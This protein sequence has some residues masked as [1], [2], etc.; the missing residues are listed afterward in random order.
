MGGISET[1]SLNLTYPGEFIDG[2]YQI[3]GNIDQRHGGIQIVM[4]GGRNWH[5]K[6]YTDNWRFIYVDTETVGCDPSE[7]S[8]VGKAKLYC[9][10]ISYFPSSITWGMRGQPLCSR[11]FFFGPPNG[12]SREM[13][14]DESIG[15]GN[16]QCHYDAHVFRNEGVKYYPR[17]DSL[18]LSRQI[19]PHEKMH[20]LEK[21]M[22]EMLGYSFNIDGKGGKFKRLFSKPKVGKNGKLLKTREAIP[23]D[24]ILPFT[25]LFNR[26]VDY[27]T[28]DTKGGLEVTYL[29]LKK[30]L[31]L[32]RYRLPDYLYETYREPGWARLLRQLAGTS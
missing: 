23:L 6:D 22:A 13:L 14:E 25:P 12:L 27:S 10:S 32:N 18:R 26:L 28:L 30:I 7:E 24:S 1:D 15:S 3:A 17:L 9:W 21:L 2:V 8:P 31:R 19:A 5:V 4:D 20:G 16:H 11:V 29:L